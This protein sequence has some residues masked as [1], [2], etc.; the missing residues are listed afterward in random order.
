M[1]ERRERGRVV[2]FLGSGASKSIC[3]W[4]PV[5]SEL[6]LAHLA[7]PLSYPHEVRDAYTCETLKRL[8][9]KMPEGEN[10]SVKPLEAAFETMRR[11][12]AEHEGV[13]LFCLLKKLS[14]LAYAGSWLVHDFLRFVRQ[15]RDTI[16][17]TNY[18]TLPEATL[19]HLGTGE[20][21]PYSGDSLHWLDH[22]ISRVRT[23]DPKFGGPRP[24]PP[25]RSILLLKL[26][27]SLSWLF[28]TNPNCQTYAFDPIW[29]NAVD[30]AR[31]VGFAPCP[32]CKSKTHR[33]R[34]VIEPPLR[35]KEYKDEAIR[36]TWEKAEYAL[37]R[38][39]KI[40]FAGFSL[41]ETDEGVR[42]LLRRAYSTGN[43]KRVTI[44]DS[45]PAAVEENYRSVYGSGMSFAPERDWKK[46]LENSFSPLKSKAAQAVSTVSRRRTNN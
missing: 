28:C 14:L 41:S 27:G 12:G 30:A 7:D 34:L 16:I 9:G 13:T 37:S 21:P 8:L 15:N 25:E 31:A 19:L 33:R 46:H 38:A 10:L 26:H 5:A 4:L 1:T 11:A 32:E 44:I 20:N 18:D 22:G 43:T 40:V 2:Y 45:D 29:Q 17:T 42:D 3:P 6:T 36:E 23:R 39:E 24:T 35:E